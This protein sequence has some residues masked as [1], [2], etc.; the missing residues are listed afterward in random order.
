MKK[1][2]LILAVVL[3][4][5]FT[6]GAVAEGKTTYALGV[7]GAYT[8]YWNPVIEALKEEG[9]TL[10]LV[11]FTDYSQ[12]NRALADKEI[13]INAFQHYKYLA[14]EMETLGYD[15]TV[16]GDTIIAPLGMYS[17]KIDDLAKIEK[18]MTIAI[19]NDASNGGRA[20]KLLEAAGFLKMDPE[21]GFL[22]EKGDILENALELD[23]LEADAAQLPSLL[24]DVDAAIINGGNA[25]S[26]GYGIE[27]A[28]L[29]ETLDSLEDS[30]YINVLVCRTEDKDD[31]I[32]A[33]IIEL[34]HTDEE[35]QL[36]FELYSGTIIPAWGG[37]AQ[38]GAN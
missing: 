18:G 11:E 25:F 16:V 37:T 10:E 26:N 19:P 23:I 29:T 36:L 9:I 12:P 1:V 20:F 4:L 22:C 15:L 30:P 31:P 17:L 24:P 13:D 38:A 28:I 2:S 14:Y 3:A 8:E 5:S 7:Q 32:F 35:A 6:F 21:K 33:R 34:L 27:D